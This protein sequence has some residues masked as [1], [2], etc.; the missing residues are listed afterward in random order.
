MIDTWTR[1]CTLRRRI[2]TH[3]HTHTHTNT[4]THTHSYKQTP[5]QVSES[6]TRILFIRNKRA[7]TILFL[8][9]Y[10]AM[11]C[12]RT[13]KTTSRFQEAFANIIQTFFT[14]LHLHNK[15]GPGQTFSKIH[16]KVSKWILVIFLSGLN[17]FP[18]FQMLS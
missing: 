1:N 4:H 12:T 17:G 3:K 15:E 6:S 14:L 7:G 16:N 10:Q 8:H 11:S 2:H 13:V 18:I 5:H 9:L